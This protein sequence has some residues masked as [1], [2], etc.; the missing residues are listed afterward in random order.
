MLDAESGAISQLILSYQHTC[1]RINEMQEEQKSLVEEA[2]IIPSV[3]GLELRSEQSRSIKSAQQFS[4]MAFFVDKFQSGD[5]C[6]ERYRRVSKANPQ[7]LKRL[8]QLEM[9]I[10]ECSS[11]LSAITSDLIEAPPA[12]M[13][14]AIRKIEFLVNIL[15][16]GGDMEILDFVFAIGECASLLRLRIDHPTVCA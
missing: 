5:N 7:N 15:M 14:E 11:H 10:S 12:G 2:L 1:I 13:R 16:E 3:N 6:P 8:Y 9:E 4:E